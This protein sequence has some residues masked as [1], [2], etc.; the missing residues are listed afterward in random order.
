MKSS[1]GADGDK[2]KENGTAQGGSPEQNGEQPPKVTHN[3]LDIA[4]YIGR[5]EPIMFF[6]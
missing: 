1:S 5:L 2:P 4:E 3:V 6:F